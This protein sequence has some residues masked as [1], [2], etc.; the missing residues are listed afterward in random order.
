MTILS[1]ELVENIQIQIC[2]F[3]YFLYSSNSKNPIQ[4]ILF[5]NG[6]SCCPLSSRTT[7]QI[8]LTNFLKYSNSNED[9]SIFSLD[10]IL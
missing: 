3:E 9:L 4:L 6:S 2:E 8:I 5:A 7:A 10:L 1:N